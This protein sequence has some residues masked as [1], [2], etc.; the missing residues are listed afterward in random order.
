MA[1]LFELEKDIRESTLANLFLEFTRGKI[2]KKTKKYGRRFQPRYRA[3]N[4]L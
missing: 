1:L 2:T 4:I 3:F